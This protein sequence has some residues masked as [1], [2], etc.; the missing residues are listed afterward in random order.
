MQQQCF[1]YI[2][3]AGTS[4]LAALVV[5]EGSAFNNRPSGF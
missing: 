1:D 4:A 5:A 3:A 2:E